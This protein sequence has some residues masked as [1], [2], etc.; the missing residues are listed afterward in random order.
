MSVTTGAS[1]EENSFQI[2]FGTAEGPGDL[3]FLT[4][5]RAL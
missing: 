1:S 4:W 5:R 3:L 2:L